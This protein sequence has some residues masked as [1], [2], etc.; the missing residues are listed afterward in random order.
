MEF[1]KDTNY[2]Y[3]M[4]FIKTDDNYFNN[5]G[6]TFDLVSNEISKAWVQVLYYYNQNF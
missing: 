3:S 5:F 4:D 1:G 2:Y 6:T